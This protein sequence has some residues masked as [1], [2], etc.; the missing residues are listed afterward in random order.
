MARQ[1]LA[2]V[3]TVFGSPGPLLLCMETG[4]KATRR[5]MDLLF[6][7]SA[8]YAQR[9]TTP[10]A[11]NLNLF[12]RFAMSLSSTSSI[13]PFSIF[14]RHPEEHEGRLLIPVWNAA[15]FFRSIFSP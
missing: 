4:I 11:A 6:P 8:A 3:D 2:E 14:H 1:I 7:C 9:P 13:S 15:F 10:G 5:A 12:Q